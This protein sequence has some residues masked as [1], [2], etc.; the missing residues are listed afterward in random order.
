MEIKMNLQF[1]SRVKTEFTTDEA[2]K[3]AAYE[4]TMTNLELDA[5]NFFFTTDMAA[6][7]MNYTITPRVIPATISFDHETNTCFAMVEI[8]IEPMPEFAQDEAFQLW[9]DDD[10]IE[11]MYEWHLAQKVGAF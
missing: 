8:E 1:L 6:D 2:D 3:L 5:L 7:F 11:A 10:L 9:D 4:S